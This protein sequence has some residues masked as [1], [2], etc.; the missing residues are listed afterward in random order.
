MNAWTSG[1][2]PPSPSSAWPGTIPGRETLSAYWENLKSGRTLIGEIPACRWPLAD[3]YEPDV[4]AA[5]HQVKSYSRV[6]GFLESFA[7][8][9]PLFFNISPA[10]ALHMDPQERLVLT[11][12]WEA[13]EASGHS[14]KA[15]QERYQGA[16]GVFIGITQSGFQLHT[17]LGATFEASRLPAT[18]FSAMA[19]RV[20][21]HLNLNGPSLAVDTMCSSAI[22]AIHEA[23]EHIRRGDCRLAFAGA[24]NLYLHPRTYIDLCRGRLISP[25]TEIHCF[26]KTGAGFIPGEGVGAVLLKP[27][28][29][30]EADGDPIWGVIEGTGVNHGGKTNGFTVPNPVQQRAIVHRVLQS[31]RSAPDDIDYIESAANGSALGDAIEFEALSRVFQPRTGAA[32]RLGSL[33]PNIGHLEAAAGMA[34]LAKVLLQLKHRTLAPTRIQPA[35][36]DASLRWEQ[37]PLQLVTQAQPWVSAHERPRKALITSYGAGGSYAALVV[38]EYFCRP[39]TAPAAVH[40]AAGSPSQLILLS[41]RT[42]EQL[43]A[44]AQRLRQWLQTGDVCLPSLAC[45]LQQGRDAMRYRLALQAQD[46][47]ELMDHLDAFV[48]QPDAARA[49]SDPVQTGDAKVVAGPDADLSARGMEARARQA[50]AGR[51]LQTLARLWTAGCDDIDWSGLHDGPVPRCSLPTYPF[52]ARAFWYGLEDAAARQGDVEA[53]GH[54]QGTQAVQTALLSV[55]RDILFM[56]DT[57]AL[58]MDATFLDLGL[59]SISVVR[60]IQQLSRKLDLP[61]RETLVF[62]YPTIG[63]LADYIAAQSAGDLLPLREH[64][65]RIMKAHAEVVPLQVEGAGPLLF[66]IHPM[67][68]DVGLYAKLA[69]AARGRFRLI[70]IKAKGFLS[71]QTPL[72]TVEAMGRCYQ[73]IIQAIDPQGPCHLL[74]ASMGGTVAYETACRL[75]HSGRAVGS[76]FLVEAPLVEND[77]DGALWHSD[78]RQNWIMNAN[79]LMITLLHLDP[80]FRRSKAQGEIR[81]PELEITPAQVADVPEDALAARLADLIVQRGVKQAREVLI[82]RLVSMSRVHLANLRALSRYRADRVPAQVGLKVWLLRTRSAHAVSADVY[83]PDYLRRVQQHKGGMAPFFEGW[84]RVLPQIETRLIDGDNHFELLHTSAAVQAMRDIIARGMGVSDAA[85]AQAAAAPIFEAGSGPPEKLRPETDKIAIVGMSGQF[86]GAATLDEFWRLLA[87][88]RSAITE[89]PTDRGWDTAR[90]SG[91]PAG[92]EITIRQGGFL[93]GIDRF[94]PVFFKIPPHEAALIDPSERIFLQEAWQAIID[95]GMDPALLAGRPW[96]VFCGGGGNYTLLIQEVSGVSPIATSSGI[97]GRVSY[98]LGLTGPSVSVD[99]GCAA[100]ALAVS[101][102]C[103]ALRLGQCEAAIAG[104]V[105]V[106]ATP[107]LI[108]S[109]SPAGVFAARGASRALARDADGMLPGEAAGVLVLKPLRQALAAGDRIHGVI[110]AWGSNHNGKTNGLSA[111]SVNAQIALLT[112]V[113][114]RFDI[115]PGTIGLLEANATGTPLGD[116]MEIQALRAVFANAAADREPPCCA[117]GSVESNIGH[118]FHASGMAH[119]IKILLAMKHQAIPPALHA[120]HLNQDLESDGSPFFRQPPHPSLEGLAR[121]DAA[122]R[123]QLFRR[124]RHQCAPGDRR[125][126]DPGAARGKPAARVS[127]V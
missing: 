70:G 38:T 100:S 21:Y 57:D 64:M 118:A 6:G 112:E 124:H 68:G 49:A 61:L 72:D 83:N 67:S 7:D 1:R 92:P 108:A 119:V 59:D 120:E 93:K 20:S 4:A 97:P 126:S 53:A 31:A 81:W 71:P 34:Q 87:D 19:N 103:D 99:A 12:C 27:L 47:E 73:E 35:R 25:E 121:S 54:G 14:R 63:A 86:P 28:A 11:T 58:D 107:N 23:C 96:G 109:L 2:R 30:A 110:E 43:Q 75:R 65:R 8:F 116:T 106:H 46:A 29:Q 52:E 89:F 78:T 98:T 45:T 115:H 5:V 101:Q 84:H 42:P 56:R 77:A 95:A 18:S 39:D 40:P 44:Y 74:G 85:P 122:G 76:L 117:L 111:P 88:G 123:N 55:I 50:L 94:D 102:A 36:L 26:S 24:V 3:F 62:D 82:Q 80:A 91:R 15:L 51:D 114:R 22:T 41:A 13:M 105:W 37:G 17:R 113:Y 127:S 9:D 32:C 69:E 90:T 79:F 60:F 104:G 125:T 16:V 10:D 48:R 66:C 33:K